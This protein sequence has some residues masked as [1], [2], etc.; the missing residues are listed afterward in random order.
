MSWLQTYFRRVAHQWINKDFNLQ[1]QIKCF[2]PHIHA[3]LQQ[4][5]STH[6]LFSHY[7]PPVYSQIQTLSK[8]GS[9]LN[10]RRV[11]KSWKENT[12]PTY[13]GC[14]T[15][16][17]TKPF[18]MFKKSTCLSLSILSSSLL[19]CS[20]IAIIIIHYPDTQTKNWINSSCRNK[21]KKS[22]T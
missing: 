11:R 6:L 22:K 14:H 19:L 8:I 3:Y 12:V 15:W 17:T 21:N 1:P 4:L 7:T 5:L 20:C 13:Y 16:L 18:N 9:V 10:K 2:H